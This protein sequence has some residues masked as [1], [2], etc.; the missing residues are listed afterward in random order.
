MKSVHLIL[1]IFAL[2]TAFALATALFDGL[3][4]TLGI[5]GIGF[6]IIIAS[7]YIHPPPRG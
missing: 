7:G 1:A 6:I 5:F 2:G 3:W 4:V